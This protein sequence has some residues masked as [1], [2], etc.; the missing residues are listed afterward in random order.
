MKE[1]SSSAP[2]PAPAVGKSGDI[3]PILGSMSSLP[4]VA[5]PKRRQ[6]AEPTSETLPNFSRV[7]PS[8]LTYITFP[9]ED[10]YQPIRPVT[11][12]ARSARTPEKAPERPVGGG[13]ILL[14]VDRQPGEPVEFLDFGTEERAIP[15]EQTPQPVTDSQVAAEPTAST[16]M[17]VDESAPEA[18]PPEPFEVS[19]LSL[20]A[21]MMCSDQ[22]DF[23]VSI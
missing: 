2:V 6:P 22:F 19:S 18:E 5:T 9:S 20:L 12:A 21:L 11:T 4:A 14:F 1:A 15:I 17:H 23:T 10:R 7:T 13:G 3:S 16:G 8:Q